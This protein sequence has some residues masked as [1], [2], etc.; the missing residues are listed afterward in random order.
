[1]TEHPV[2]EVVDPG[3]QTTIQSYPGR[4]G[5]TAF[6][7]FPAGPMDQRSFRSANILVGNSVS[8]A[9]LEIPKIELTLA[10]IVETQIAVCGP[11][12]IRVRIDNATVPA[13]QTAHAPAGARVRIDNHGNVGYRAYLAVRGGFDATSTYGSTTTSVIAGIG[14]IEGR[15]LVRGDLL[16]APPSQPVVACRIPEALRPRFSNDWEIEIVPGPQCHPD[17]LTVADWNE[18]LERTWRVDLNSDR[19]ATRLNPHRFT[20]AKRDVGVAGGHPSNVLDQAYPV[21]ALLATGDVLT[22]S[23]MEGNTSGGFAVVATVPHCSYWKFGQ[24]RPGRDTVKFREITYS[25]ALA[26]D[27]RVE[28]TLD[29]ARTAPVR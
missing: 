16:S 5:L 3:L 22:I 7:Y 6:G 14:G 11:E 21:G 13:W 23:G 19:V 29:S 4:V 2:F 24:M 12:S 26:L 10:A 27:G 15:E 9:G 18:L 25:E 1:M 17:F 20:W 8:A 28:F